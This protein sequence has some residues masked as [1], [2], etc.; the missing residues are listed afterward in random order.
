MTKLLKTKKTAF[1]ILM[2]LFVIVVSFALGVHN[3]TLY[4]PRHGFDGEAHVYYINYLFQKK[5]LPKPGWEISGK[6][7]ETHQPPI[8]YLI[9]AGLM[10]FTGN[11]KIAQYI[12]IFVLWMIIGM[13]GLGLWKVFKKWNQVLIGMF[14]LAALPMLNIFPAMV[15]NE[16][17]NTFWIISAAVSCIYIVSTKKNH[18]FYLFMVWLT[19]SIILGVWTKVSIV[20]IIP[21]V[22]FTFILTFLNKRINF[23][24][25]V[26]SIFIMIFLIGLLSWPIIMRSQTV[27]NGS[28][29]INM[30]S[31][32]EYVFRPLDYYFRLDW[33]PKVDMYNTQYYSMLG[34]AWNSFWTD[35]HNAITPFIKFHKKSFILWS[36]GFLLLPLTLYGLI[37]FSKSNRPVSCIV[38]ITGLTMIFIYVWSNLGIYSH[39]SSARLTYEMGIIVPYAF[40][41]A[42]AAQN[43]K[44]KDLLLMLLSVQFIVMISFFWILPWWHVTK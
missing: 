8:Y 12:N 33:I 35:G 31:T 3:A 15:T 34:A 29:L 11:W 20:L 18:E 27:P 16:L 40:G 36:F 22:I 2:I 26:I 7:G 43:R 19:I 21:T 4:N 23:K 24:T 13:V 10:N 41:I 17:L 44:L 37:K 28:N 9:G 38:N 14:S 5:S 39:Y 30:V 42:S 32:K 25:I 6:Y 1:L